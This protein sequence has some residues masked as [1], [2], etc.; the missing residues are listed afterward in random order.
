[1]LGLVVDPRES[2]F[3]DCERENG[4]EEERERGRERG[5]REEKKKSRELLTRLCF[6]V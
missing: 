4:R 6:C 1:M 3:C 5:V 2:F